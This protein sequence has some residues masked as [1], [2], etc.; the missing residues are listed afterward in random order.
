MKL[1]LLSGSLVIS[2]SYGNNGGIVTNLW[3]SRLQEGICKEGMELCMITPPVIQNQREE[4]RLFM[5]I[6]ANKGIFTNNELGY[7][8]C[9]KIWTRVYS[10]E[11]ITTRYRLWLKTEYPKATTNHLKISS[12]W[13]ITRMEVQDKALRK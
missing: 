1:G 10:L 13:T 2:L 3:I 6:I 12:E 5:E 8:N 4:Y 9:Y 7:I 11:C